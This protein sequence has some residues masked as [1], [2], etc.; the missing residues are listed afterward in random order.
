MKSLLLAASLFIATLAPAAASMPELSEGQI[1]SLQAA[2][3]SHI[4]AASVDGA[5]LEVNTK[6]GHLRQLYPAK[7]HPMIMAVGSYFVLCSDF[8]TSTGENENVNFYV[9]KDGDRYIVFATTFGHDEHLTK[10][11]DMDMAET[12]N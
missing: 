10:M 9:A 11:M 5:L 3:Q 1:A 8:R 4:D 12:A 6:D 2:M 7:A